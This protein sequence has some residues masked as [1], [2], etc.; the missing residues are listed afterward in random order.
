MGRSTSKEVSQLVIVVSTSRLFFMAPQTTP[1]PSTLL[2]SSPAQ[3]VAALPA[4]ERDHVQRVYDAVAE[5]WH[6]T[7]YKAWPRAFAAAH[8]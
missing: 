4:L 8:T 6:G 7:R 2:T 5:Q 1:V 3:T